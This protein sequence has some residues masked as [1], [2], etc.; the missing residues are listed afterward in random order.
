MINPF[1]PK[2]DQFQIPQQPHQKYYT[3]QYE[4][5]GFSSLAQM[6][7]DC[8]TNS[9]YLIYRFH[10]KGWENGLFHLTMGC[11][12]IWLQILHSAGEWDECRM[13]YFGRNVGN[14]DKRAGLG[15]LQVPKR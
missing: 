2:S 6:K 15:Y 1:T 13:L 4:E 10:L 3:T 11:G 9:H 5:L 8:T 14:P 12:D 7:Y